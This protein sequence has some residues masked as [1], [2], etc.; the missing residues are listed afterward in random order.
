MEDDYAEHD[1]PGGDTA[2]MDER[3]DYA[4]PGDPR[5]GSPLVVLAIVGAT[6]VL[7]APVFLPLLGWFL[8]TG[9]GP[10]D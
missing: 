3:D 2:G 6:L 7:V 5:C 4:E 1:S 9:L 8:K 10:K